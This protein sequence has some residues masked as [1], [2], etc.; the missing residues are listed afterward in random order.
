[1]RI[2]PLFSLTSSTTKT[3]NIR[4]S[5]GKWS[6]EKPPERIAVINWTL[7]EQLLE[8]DFKPVAVADI[9]GFEKAAPD[10]TIPEG[11]TDIGSRFAPHLD[12]L[13]E[14]KPDLIIIGYSQRDLLRPLSNTKRI[15]AFASWLN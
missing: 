13:K 3:I 7:T 8:L 4:D 2:N 1:M 12:K 10:T 11:I 9:P 15:N 6:F 14:T 5:H